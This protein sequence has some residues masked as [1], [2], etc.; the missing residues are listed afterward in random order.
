MRRCVE[1]LVYRDMA[2]GEIAAALGISAGTVK[3]HL[4]HA[5]DRLRAA[6]QVDEGDKGS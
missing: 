2:Q 5:R 1:L 4:S 3:A 6:L